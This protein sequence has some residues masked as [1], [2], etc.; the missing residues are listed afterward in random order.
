[1]EVIHEPSNRVKI[2]EDVNMCQV[3][4]VVEKS[5]GTREVVMEAVTSLEV[6][7]AGVT[8]TTFFEDPLTVTGVVVK[9]IDFL[10]GEII[11]KEKDEGNGG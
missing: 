10:G 2:I 5:G 6:A 8:L 7:P 4:A 9:R 11:L 1:M 3:S